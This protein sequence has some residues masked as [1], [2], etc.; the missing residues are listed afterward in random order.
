MD[1]S[2]L[3]G[4]LGAEQHAAHQR[5]AAYVKGLCEHYPGMCFTA[6][7]E[8][9]VEQSLRGLHLLLADLSCTPE[10]RRAIEEFLAIAGGEVPGRPYAH[11]SLRTV[12][13]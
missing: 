6:R 1:V 5:V 13:L 2:R 9:V 8:W 11:E 4:V 12:D 7:E 10:E 3:A